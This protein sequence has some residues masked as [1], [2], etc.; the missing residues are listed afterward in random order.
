MKTG[1][2]RTTASGWITSIVPTPVPTPRP[3]R[4]PAKTDQIAPAT[5]AAAHSA[6]AS[7]SVPPVTNLASRT[8]S[9]PLARSPT[10]TTAAHFRPSARSA[11][12]PPVR[13]GSDRPGIRATRRPGHEHAH[14]DRAGEVRDQHQDDGAEDERWVQ[15]HAP[16]VGLG[17]SPIG[18]PRPESS[19]RAPPASVARLATPRVPSRS[20]DP[21][22]QPALQAVPDMRRARAAQPGLAAL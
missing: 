2:A 20:D 3:L 18:R 15:R 11:F 16:G 8:G 7:G 9:A 17:A 6:S 12:V 10:T 14:R 13:P 19:T 22:A 5:A 4:K 21:P 1:A